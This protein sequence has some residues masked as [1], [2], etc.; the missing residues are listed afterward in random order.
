M[1]A[2]ARLARWRIS[3]ENQEK[4]FEAKKARKVKYLM[5][6]QSLVESKIQD[7]ESRRKEIEAE[8]AKIAEEKFISFDTFREDAIRRSEETKTPKSGSN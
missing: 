4:I 6:Q 3:Y 5:E 1:N 8:L 7:L 2:D